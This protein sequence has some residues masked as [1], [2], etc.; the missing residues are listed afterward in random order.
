[1]P[2]FKLV[3]A[4]DGTRYAGWQRQKN[5][6]TVQGVVEEAI[7]VVT[8]KAATLI[9]AGRTD[10][11]VHAEGMV[12]NFLSVT[13]IPV[14][15][16]VKA[17]NNNL[18]SDIRVLSAEIV[19]NDFQARYKAKR[20]VYEYT[21]VVAA[22]MPPLQRLYAA[23]VTHPVDLSA[24]ERCIPFLV[25]THDFSSFE[26][27]GSRDRSLTNG[28]GAVRTIYAAGVQRA[29]SEEV[30]LRI[31]LEGDGFLR[32]MVRNIVGTLLEVGKGR[33]SPDDFA[34]I[35]ASCDRSRAGATA[36]ACGLNL[37]EV[38]Y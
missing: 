21:F 30:V 28:K 33:A 36:P 29:G 35:L 37:K 1:V 27:S 17:L 4:Y 12:A 18:P 2:N 20:K 24:I 34:A 15:G 13:L 8:G 38:I 6:A 31:T 7:A 32:H 26:A 9:G 11:G 10:A 5:Q 25:G 3:L 19:A 23:H 16:L 14:A 22:I